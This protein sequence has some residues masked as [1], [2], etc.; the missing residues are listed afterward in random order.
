M[1]DLMANAKN[2]VQEMGNSC[3]QAATG[4]ADELRNAAGYVADQVKDVA[5]QAGN[6][7]GKAGSY[8]ESKADE[9]TNAIGG[10]LKAASESVRNYAPHDGRFGQASS[11]IAQGL[12]DTGEYIEREG[13][14]GMTNDLASL[15]KKNPIPTVLLGIGLGFLIARASART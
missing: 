11:A 14:Q 2:K 8:I 7:A 1:A 10:G 12:S 6:Q 13:L 3:A 5:N 9:A 4:A 15:I